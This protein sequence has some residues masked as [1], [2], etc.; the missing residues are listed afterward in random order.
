MQLIILDIIENSDTFMLPL[1]PGVSAFIHVKAIEGEK[2]K[3][4]YRKGKFNG[5]DFVQSGFTGYQLSYTY[6]VRN[7]NR[8]ERPIY[9]NNKLKDKFYEN[10][11][12]GKVY[13]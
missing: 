11:N 8:K 3:E 7:G 9:I 6:T 13:Y 5:I 10:I 2:F 4:S 1:K 12:N